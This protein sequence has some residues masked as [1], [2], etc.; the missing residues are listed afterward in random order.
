MIYILERISKEE[1][2]K[3]KPDVFGTY[4]KLELEDFSEVFRVG[5]VIRELGEVTLDTWNRAK[6]YADAEEGFVLYTQRYS[7]NHVHDGEIVVEYILKNSNGPEEK[8]VEEDD[9]I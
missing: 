9:W 3:Y 8:N 2:G 7:T 5:E 4:L 1:Y 6:K